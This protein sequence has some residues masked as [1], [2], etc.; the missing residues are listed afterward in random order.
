MSELGFKLQHIRNL[1]RSW[2]D[3]VTTPEEVQ[4]ILTQRCNLNCHFCFNKDTTKKENNIN[5]IKEIVR[6]TKELGIEAIRFTGG[7]PLL[8]KDLLESVIY[9]KQQGLYVI[10]NTNGLLIDESNYK[11]FD[12]VDDVLISLHNVEELNS[13]ERAFN[14]LKRKNLILRGCTI[15]LKENIKELEKFFRFFKKVKFN[16]YFLLRPI[17]NPLNKTPME[18]Q[19][20]QDFTKKI[21]QLNNTYKA[22]AYIANALPF[23]SYDTEKLSQICVGGKNDSG[24]TRI[25]VA[26]NGDIKPSYYSNK[27]LG[28]IKTDSLK[29]CW[30]NHYMKKIRNHQLV[31][32]E[33]KS[34]HHLHVC[35]GG[36][37]GDEKDYLIKTTL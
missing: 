27:I 11:I 4:V 2:R 28:N 15:L 13:K 29:E 25:T 7:E 1:R 9:A 19:D 16:N 32:T 34:C 6:Q 21:I 20:V 31:P 36:I 30:N 37:I 17:P 23:C 10:I 33:C 26:E 8:V 5:E 35:K 3:K 14:K 22:N 12:Y 24:Y 18:T